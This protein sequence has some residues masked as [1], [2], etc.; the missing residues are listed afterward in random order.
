MY[1]I[2]YT[3]IIQYILLLLGCIFDKKFIFMLCVFLCLYSCVYSILLTLM[4]L[5]GAQQRQSVYPSVSILWKWGLGIHLK[6]TVLYTD[7]D[8]VIDVDIEIYIDIEIDL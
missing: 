4:S 6:S 8:R 3:S 7:T 2:L 1:L 5:A